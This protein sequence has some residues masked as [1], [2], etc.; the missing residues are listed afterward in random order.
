MGDSVGQVA[1]QTMLSMLAVQ[2]ATDLPIYRPLAGMDKQEIIDI[3][4]KIDTFE[5]S[6]RPYEDCCTVFVPKTPETKPKRNIIE[7]IAKK[8]E[9]ELD[10]MLDKAIEDAEIITF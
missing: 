3:A 10:P 7:N 8:L 4:H 1:S 5:I 9:E 6:A 2:G